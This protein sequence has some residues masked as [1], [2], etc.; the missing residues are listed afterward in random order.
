MREQS[1]HRM[2]FADAEIAK[3]VLDTSGLVIATA[4]P[5]SLHVDFGQLGR[6]DPDAPLLA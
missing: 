5:A 3:P 4:L 2:D 1:A 6:V